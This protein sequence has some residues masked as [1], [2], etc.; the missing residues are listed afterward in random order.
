M[1]M[2]YSYFRLVRFTHTIFGLPFAIIG[3][4]FG[5]TKIETFPSI[6]ILIPIL[7]CL[8][9]ARNAA[10]S[11]N[12]W[13]DREIDAENPRTKNREI[14]AQIISPQSVLLFVSIN[15]ALF[16]LSSWFINPICFYLSPLALFVIFAYSYTKH[17]TYFC[18]FFLGLALMIAPVGAYMAITANLD[19]S[20]ILLGLSVL[21]WVSG[22]DIIYSLQDLEFDQQNNLHSIPAQFGEAKSKKIAFILHIIS[23]YLLYLWTILYLTNNVLVYMGLLIYSILILRQHYI[24]RRNPNADLN[25]LFVY[26]NGLG[27]IILSAFISTYLLITLI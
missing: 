11:F 2:I 10:M 27:S 21:V 13:L 20:I 26:H 8:I 16:I 25:K 15:T 24:I 4:M 17:Y 9:F 7:L 18:H 1:K 19:I 22:F 5:L 14:P 3:L 6:A 23:L 12:R